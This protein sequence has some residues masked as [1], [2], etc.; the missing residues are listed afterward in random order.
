MRKSF[1]QTYVCMYI[2]HGGELGSGDVEL[3]RRRI[4]YATVCRNVKLP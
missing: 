2:I 4:N 3:I 1:K